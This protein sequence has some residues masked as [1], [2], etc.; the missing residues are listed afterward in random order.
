MS[1]KLWGNN[2]SVFFHIRQQFRNVY[3]TQH[4][5]KIQL[6]KNQKKNFSH[7]NSFSF[8]FATWIAEKLHQNGTKM[9]QKSQTNQASFRINHRFSPDLKTWAQG[10]DWQISKV[11]QNQCLLDSKISTFSRSPSSSW[12]DSLRHLVMFAMVFFVCDCYLNWWKLLC[13]GVNR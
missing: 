12:V 13:G 5:R 9:F 4:V 11:F 10:H 2:S 8:H 7:G 1:K 3:H 6:V